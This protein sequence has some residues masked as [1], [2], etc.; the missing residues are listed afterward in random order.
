MGELMILLKLGYQCPCHHSTYPSSSFHLNS[1]V[2]SHIP[3]QV[4]IPVHLPPW[5]LS[6]WS[7]PPLDVSMHHCT[8]CMLIKILRPYNNP[9]SCATCM[10]NNKSYNFLGNTPYLGTKP[11]GCSHN[12]SVITMLPLP[13][14]AGSFT[15]LKP[16]TLS[17]VPC[18]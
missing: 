6:K 13:S 8:T 4:R 15:T 3:P 17:L 1:Q 9:W 7:I 10:P 11:L 2:R 18:P 14:P 16:W 5:Y 12:T